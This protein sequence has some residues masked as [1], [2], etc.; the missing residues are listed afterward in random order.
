MRLRTAL[1]MALSC[2]VATGAAGCSDD[3]D[4]CDPQAQTGCDGN[5]V[6]EEVVDE[7]P[8]CFDPVVIRGSVF[9]LS[10]QAPIERARVVAL[11][12]NR[13]AASSVALS[14]A[15]GNYQLAIPTPRNKDGSPASPPT[16]TLRADASGFQTFP[17]GI[18]YALPVDTSQPV[19]DDDALVVQSSLTDIGLLALEGDAGAGVVSGAVELPDE[20][21]GI[22]VVA[23]AD[24]QG[25]SAVADRDGHYAILNLPDGEYDV[26]AYARGVNYA[27]AAA[28][29]PA[30]GDAGVEL[31][32]DLTD[33][34]A[35]TV[36]G[37]V[38][39][40]NPG[41]GKATSVVMV[42]AST[43]DPVLGR[44][45]TVPGLRSPDPGADLDVTGDFTI[46][47]VPAGD[48]VIL[49]AFENDFL[50]RDPD[51][52]IAGTDFVSQTVGDDATIEIPDAFKVTG[53]LDVLG[54]GAE[55]PEAVT[56]TPTFTWVDDSSED[57]YRV[58]VLDSL[59][60]VVW[61]T[62]A[63][64][65]TGD[66][67]AVTYAGP[68]LEPGMYY[69]FRATSIRDSGG[70]SCE[71]SQTEDLKGVFFMEPPAPAAP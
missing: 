19:A 3:D 7:E 30:D 31:N 22:L 42:V 41:E 51:T 60:T 62:V 37:K 28:A 9:D 16:L 56:E 21:V 71:I 1:V 36:S 32:L 2:A 14:D 44:G 67:P 45:E 65:A 64:G 4:T 53:A 11:D 8:A 35:S 15:D 27:S 33:R 55:A 49:A 20:R 5:E 61:E 57:S 18:R 40:V 66:D 43:F 50:V 25:Y 10:D 13:A 23:E 48:Y 54:P 24:G 6:C 69:Q 26:T 17:S 68:P 12:P 39:M 46:E 38:E 70:D 52:C 63:D 29:L 59:G 47:G 34:P 58:V